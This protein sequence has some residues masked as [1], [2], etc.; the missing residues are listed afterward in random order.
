MIIL[1]IVLTVATLG[2]GY[3]A[4]RKR[5]N[6]KTKDEP[7]FV[8]NDKGELS[9]NEVIG[10]GSSSRLDAREDIMHNDADAAADDDFEHAELPEAV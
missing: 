10:N 4:Y 8:P 9:H 1:I 2:I 5:R 6:N 3:M 7:V